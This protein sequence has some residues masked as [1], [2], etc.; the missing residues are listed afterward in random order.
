[1]I[2]KLQ[3]IPGDII[4]PDVLE[5]KTGFYDIRES[6]KL[7]DK[8]NNHCRALVNQ[9][10]EEYEKK[11]Q[12]SN[13]LFSIVS[14]EFGDSE[15][16]NGLCINLTRL[17]EEKDYLGYAVAIKVKTKETENT[18]ITNQRIYLMNDN[19]ETIEKVN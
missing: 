6:I 3:K 1:M 9:K 12:D 5:V 4:I 10:G 15:I 19:G 17:E 14:Y 7:F 2:V 18:Y 16:Q 13:M 11:I 8:S